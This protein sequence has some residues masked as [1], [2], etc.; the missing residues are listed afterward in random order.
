MVSNLRQPFGL[1]FRGSTL[2]V[3]ESNQIDSYTY[4]DGTLSARRVLVT[5]LPD[6]KSPQLHGTYAHALKGLAV[7][8]DFLFLNTSIARPEAIRMLRPAGQPIPF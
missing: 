6:S 2:Y 4:R 3:G 5:D 8:R 1:A 7:G